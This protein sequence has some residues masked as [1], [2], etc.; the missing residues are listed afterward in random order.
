MIICLVTLVALW[1]WRLDIDEDD[2]H[3]DDGH[4]DY[5]H[6]DDD[7]DDHEDDDDKK[8][9]VTA[10]HHGCLDQH[11]EGVHSLPAKRQI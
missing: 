6:E 4:E 11:L 7:H 8:L 3:E 9:S 5:D 2:D 10:A 1:W